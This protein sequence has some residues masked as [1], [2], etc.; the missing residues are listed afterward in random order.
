MQKCVM[1][2]GHWLCPPPGL[3]VR[4]IRHAEVC[5]SWGTLAVPTTRAGG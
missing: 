1:L 3:V 5:N 4:V 2:G